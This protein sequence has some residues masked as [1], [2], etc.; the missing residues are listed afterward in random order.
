MWMVALG[1][2]VFLQAGA[3]PAAEKEGDNGAVH[4]ECP[5]E[6][7]GADCTADEAAV[8]GEA[9]V[10]E[11]QPVAPA[12]P[13]AVAAVAPAPTAFATVS[14]RNDVGKKLRLVEAHFTMDGEKLPIVLTNAEPGKSYVIVSGAVKPG[15]HVVSARLVYR[16]DRGVFSYMKGYKL[17]V[18][19]AQVLTATADRRVN[20]TV[21]GRENK[22]M[23]VPIERRVTVSVEDGGASGK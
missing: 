6:S 9:V 11:A 12:T 1:M 15:P 20:F 5:P 21:V 16:G 4:V 23:N 14:F 17:N 18:R 22:G 10:P 13:A 2:A 7:A 19:S 3:T 8:P